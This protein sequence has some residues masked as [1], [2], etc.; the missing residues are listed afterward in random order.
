MNKNKKIVLV[1]VVGLIVVGLSFWGGMKYSNSKN[2]SSQFANRGQNGFNQNGEMRI[3]QGT[4]NGLNGGLVNGE[5]ISK[6]DKSITVKLRDGGS[7]STQGGSKIVFFSPTTEVEKTV[8]GSIVDI[9]IGKQVTIMGTANPDGSVSA[10]SI[11]I[12]P[13]LTQN[14]PPIPNSGK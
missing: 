13:D 2:P 4:R 5:I 7:A 6:D 12:R 9:I 11:Q 8:D 10:T 14:N 1:I 3:G